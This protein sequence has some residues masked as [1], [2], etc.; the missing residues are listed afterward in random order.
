MQGER[1]STDNTSTEEWKNTKVPI[2]LSTYSPDDI[3]NADETGLYCRTTP[4]GSLCYKH[5]ALSGFKKAMDRITVF[6]CTYMSGHGRLSCLG[7]RRLADLTPEQ[8]K[9]GTQCSKSLFGKKQELDVS[10]SP[11]VASNIC[12]LVRRKSTEIDQLPGR[13]VSVSTP[14]TVIKIN[15]I[16]RGDRH[17]SIRMIA[18]IVNADKQSEKFYMMN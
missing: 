5:I 17:M 16:M 12:K 2:Y 15:E 14:Q 18:E 8:E 13:P 7:V 10:G 4:Y 6:C 1:S 3:Y 9:K 11:S